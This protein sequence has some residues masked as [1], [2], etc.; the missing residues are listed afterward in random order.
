MRACFPICYAYVSALT[1][2]DC[3]RN[4]LKPLYSTR[5]VLRRLGRLRERAEDQRYLGI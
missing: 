4:K 3:D 1:M 5:D 2:T